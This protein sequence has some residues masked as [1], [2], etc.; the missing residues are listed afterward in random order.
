M[1]RRVVFSLCGLAA[2][3]IV[4]AAAPARPATTPEG[5][6][7][8]IGHKAFSS[9]SPANLTDEERI[10]RFRSLLNEAFDLK[11]IGRFV[12]GIYWRRATDEQKAE[13]L[14]LFEKFVV[15]AYANRFRD[16]SDKKFI[17][18]KA[19]RLND[20]DSRVLSE[21]D[22]P[23]QKPIDVNWTVRADDSHFKIIDVA[24]EGISMSVTQRDEFASVIQQNGGK[25]QGLI[26]AL[27]RKTSE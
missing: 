10:R 13:F 2:L 8:T 21:I 4:S 27:K 5:Y 23:G 25:V 26:D 7:E 12:L 17:V 24:V 3:L 1:S 14:V 16:L 19:Q 11:H 15:Q 22:S 9:L 18:K 20:T 6:I